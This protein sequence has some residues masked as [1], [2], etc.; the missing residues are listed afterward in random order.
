MEDISVHAKD[1]QISCAY[2]IPD[3][4]I[5]TPDEFVD[6][7]AMQLFYENHSKMQEN[8]KKLSSFAEKLTQ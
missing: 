5:A 4:T 8:A 7:P 1:Q 6:D 2:L 3:T